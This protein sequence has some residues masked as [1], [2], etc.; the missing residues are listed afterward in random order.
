MYGIS[1]ILFIT[2]ERSEI[3]LSSLF[4]V[5]IYGSTFFDS[6]ISTPKKNGRIIVSDARSFIFKL[7]ISIL[8]ID[9]YAEM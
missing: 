1:D 9:D 4:V 2:R 5:R 7:F 3:L 8:S 6:I